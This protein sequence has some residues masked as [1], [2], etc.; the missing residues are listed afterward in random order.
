MRLQALIQCFIFGII[1]YMMRLLIFETEVENLQ[2]QSGKQEFTDVSRNK[3][4]E[5]LFNRLTFEIDLI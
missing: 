5:Y 4:S 3:N 1:V 2:S